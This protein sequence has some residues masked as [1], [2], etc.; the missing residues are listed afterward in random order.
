MAVITIYLL[1]IM[2]AVLYFDVSRYLIPNWLTGSLLLVYP[3]AVW[4]AHGAVEWKPA[5]LAMAIVLAAGY[6]VFALKWMGGGDIKL[7]AVCALWV[8]LKSLIDF[9]FLVAV[10]GGVFAIVLWSARKV[11]PHIPRQGMALPRLLRE[12]EPVPYGV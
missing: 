12:G 9:L 1:F 2:L 5:L 6:A 3:V 11:I 8:G 10:I 4:M 7:L